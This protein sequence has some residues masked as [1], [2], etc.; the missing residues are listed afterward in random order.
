MQ[1]TANTLTSEGPESHHSEPTEPVCQS[2]GYGHN[3]KPIL[4]DVVQE[5]AQTTWLSLTHSE[6]ALPSTLQ[7]MTDP[8]P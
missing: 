2:E 1:A 3:Q 4:V 7:T 8:V 5:G 6:S